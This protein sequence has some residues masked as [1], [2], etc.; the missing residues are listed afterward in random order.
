MEAPNS[1][2]KLYK[3]LADAQMG[4]ISVI[5]KETKLRYEQCET[6]FVDEIQP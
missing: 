4:K 5:R 1:V 2:D 3:S 6:E